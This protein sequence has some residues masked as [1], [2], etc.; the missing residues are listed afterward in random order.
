M[1]DDPNATPAMADDDADNKTEV[2]A[3][4]DTPVVKDPEAEEG[5]EG[6]I[7]AGVDG[8]G[9]DDDDADDDGDADETE[10]VA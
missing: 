5:A 10:T 6:G 2:T 1:N 4:G 9:D 3:E 8:D 7:E